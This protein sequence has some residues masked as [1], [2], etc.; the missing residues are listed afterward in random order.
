[1]GISDFA[2][3]LASNPPKVQDHGSWQRDF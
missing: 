3:T 2:L 1:V